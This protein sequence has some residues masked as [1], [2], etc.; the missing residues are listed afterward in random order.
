MSIADCDGVLFEPRGSQKLVVRNPIA[1][2]EE[3][4]EEKMWMTTGE[5]SWLGA[6]EVAARLRVDLR[7]GLWGRE[8]ELRRQLAGYNEFSVKEDDPLWQKYLEQVGFRL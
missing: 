2:W 5:A 4:E 7:T 8:P 1:D 3:E 6:E